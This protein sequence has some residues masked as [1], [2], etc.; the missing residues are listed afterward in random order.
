[1]RSFRR[2]LVC[3]TGVISVASLFLLLRAAP[4]Y[5]VDEVEFFCNGIS[6]ATCDTFQLDGSGQTTANADT[7]VGILI[8]PSG[9]NAGSSYSCINSAVSEEED[10]VWPADWDALL[11]PTLTSG[12]VTPL[13][14]SPPGAYSFALPWGGFGSFSGVFPST[15]VSSG[16]STI[17]K[18]GTKN[19]DD[20]SKWVVAS[21]SSPPKDAYLA[22]A[23]ASYKAPSTTGHVA[24]GDELLYFGSTRFAPNG[25]ATVGIW[26]FQQNVQVCPSGTAM[27]VGGTTTIANHKKGDL[28]LFLTFSGSGI[29]TIQGA[30]WTADGTAGTL[31]PIPGTISTCPGAGGDA[32]AVTNAASSIT[33]GSPSGPQSPGTGFNVAGGGFPNGFPGGVVPALQFQEGGIDLN[34]FFGGVAPC[35][36]SVLFASVTSGSSPSTASMKSIILG[37]FNTCKI[38]VTKSCGDAT[39]NIANGTLTYPISGTVQNVGGGGV[40]DLSLTDTFAGSSQSFDSGTPTC[41]CGTGCTITGTDC[42]TAQVN[43]GGTVSYL[44]TITTSTN[45]GSDVVTATMAGAGGGSPTA[46]SN[47]ATCNP[48]H[49]SPG[50]TITKNCTPGASLVA[51]GGVVAVQVGV[52]GTVTNTSGGGLSLSNVAVY[53]CVNGTFGMPGTGSCPTVDPS[54]CSGTLRNRN[55]YT[56][57]TANGTAAWSDTYNPSVAPSGAPFNFSDQVLVSASC[58]S[59]FCTCSTVQNVANQTCPLCPGP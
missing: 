36:S 7:C 34:S 18:Q 38:T 49:F 43:P 15:L 13:T 42:T 33:L 40:S 45:G 35:F 30:V 21:Q 28:F 54:T 29:A 44:A 23:L 5:A 32:C 2:S 52:D 58:N 8:P 16:S 3:L 37:N 31:G 41:S 11:Y 10:P 22:A 59:T 1:M 56:S 47:T 55:T 39:A 48:K 25:S 20:L 4:A 6:G 19:T 57:I 26:F 14:G 53:D 27:C 51:S 50:I 24:A 12:T 46:Q 9:T 17:L